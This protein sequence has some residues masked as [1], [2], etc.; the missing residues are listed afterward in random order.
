MPLAF[1]G[2]DGCRFLLNCF[3]RETCCILDSVSIVLVPCP[4]GTIHV[5][6][7]TWL[8]I[9]DSCCGLKRDDAEKSGGGNVPGTNGGGGTCSGGGTGSGGG[10]GAGNGMYCS[11]STGVVPSNVSMLIG[12]C[13]SA[14]VFRFV[15]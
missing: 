9:S 7:V 11:C 6:F 5:C 13:D 15:L 1:R 10:G 8:G 14:M 3:L 12:C 4:L 2:G